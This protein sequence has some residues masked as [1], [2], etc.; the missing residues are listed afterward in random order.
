[1]TWKDILDKNQCTVMIF[2]HVWWRALD[3][4]DK[5]KSKE[6]KKKHVVKSHEDTCRKDFF[7]VFFAFVKRTRCVKENG[8]IASPFHPRVIAG[9]HHVQGDHSFLQTRHNVEAVDKVGDSWSD[10]VSQKNAFCGCGC[11]HNKLLK[12]R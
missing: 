6:S 7:D 2:Q 10:D 9:M 12:E 11:E 8:L 5:P 1:M 4:K 3:V